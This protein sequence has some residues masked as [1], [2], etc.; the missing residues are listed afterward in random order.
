MTS[1]VLWPFLTYLPTLSYSIMSFLGAMYLG[2][3]SYPNLGRHSLIL[4]KVGN[5]KCTY[6]PDCKVAFMLYD[7]FQVLINFLFIYENRP[8]F[9]W[10]AT[11]ALLRFRNI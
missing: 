10:F 7:F 8:S 2:P 6:L 4:K 1:H 11:T 5:K 3:T 9:C